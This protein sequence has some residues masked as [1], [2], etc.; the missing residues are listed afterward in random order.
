MAEKRNAYSLLVVVI[1][2]KEKDWKSYVMMG[3]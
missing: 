1:R 2:S 3:V